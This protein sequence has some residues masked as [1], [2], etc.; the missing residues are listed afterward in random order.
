AMRAPIWPHGFVGSITHTAGLAAAVAAR[1]RDARA[2][3][4]DIERIIGS[5]AVGTL[6]HAVARPDELRLVGRG[7]LDA[8]AAFATVFATKEAL[9]KCLAPLVGRYFDFLDVEVTSVTRDA[10]SFRLRAEL[11]DDFRAGRTFK[12]R[13]ALFGH[14]V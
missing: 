3:G 10:L 1:A 7:S 6:A 4:V 13:F 14:M 5:D 9:F 12:A 2:L 8:A 11:A